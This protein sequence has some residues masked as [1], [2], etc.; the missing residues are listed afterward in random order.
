MFGQ[1]FA[2]SNKIATAE[3]QDV[4][5][6]YID[7]PGDL[8]L[9]LKNNTLKKFDSLG[10]LLYEK[11]HA[12]APTLFDPRDGARL[13]MYQKETRLCSFYSDETKQEFMV[14]SHYA[15]DPVLACSSGDHN[16][17]V[18]DRADLSLKCINPILTKVT[19]ELPIDQKQFSVQPQF[20]SM[21]EYQNFLFLL[22]KNSGIL[23]FN[24]LGI[25]VKK[26]FITDIDFFNFLGEELYFKKNDTLYFLDLFDS[27]THQESV[28]PLCT[29]ILITDSRRFIIYP[30]RLEIYKNR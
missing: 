28:D 15:I 4:A 10:N 25:Q 27:S 14:E 26:I 12:V 8:Y 9:L 19:A 5:S 2:Q 20:T 21:R 30:N 3:L 11:K 17:W 23:I 22:D 24:R 13:F 7:R 29:F 1:T 18:L 16:V 6:A